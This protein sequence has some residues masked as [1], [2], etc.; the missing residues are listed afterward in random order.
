MRRLLPERVALPKPSAKDRLR[1]T[2]L[3]LPGSEPNVFSV[4]VAAN[5]IS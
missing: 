5:A 1:R 2:R 3:Y 4:M